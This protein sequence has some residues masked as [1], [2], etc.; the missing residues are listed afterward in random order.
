[1]L[2]FMR[3]LGPQ[4]TAAKCPDT[5]VAADAARLLLGRGAGADGPVRGQAEAAVWWCDARVRDPEDAAAPTPP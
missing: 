4:R 5:R 1:M 3:H 2:C